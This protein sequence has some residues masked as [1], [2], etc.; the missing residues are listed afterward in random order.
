MGKITIQKPDSVK[1]YKIR[2][3]LD[4]LSQKTGRG[5]ELIS[6]YI[7]NGKQLHEVIT[8]LREE[9]GTADNIK[10]DLTRT[11]VVDSLS[12]V[13]QRLKL[14]KKTPERG[15]VIFCGALPPEEGGPL[16]SEVVKV[17]EIDPPKDLKTFLYRCDDHFHVDILKNMLKD[18]NLIGFLAIDAKD[19][20]WGLLHGDKSEV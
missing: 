7:P 8:N 19:A 9:Q 16:G 4:E 14:Y 3:I 20:G 17:Y 13:L 15:L 10:S 18:E 5:T 2:K 6:L 12:K 11:H 1:L